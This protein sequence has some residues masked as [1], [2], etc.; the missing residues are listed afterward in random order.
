MP[1]IIFKHLLRKH[2]DNLEKSASEINNFLN[3]YDN[4][5]Q[6]IKTEFGNCISELEDLILKVSVKQSLKCRRLSTFL[7]SRRNK[8]FVVKKVQ[9]SPFIHF[10][11]KYPKRLYQTSYDDIW[12]VY[13]ELI[14]IIRQME[15]IK[16]NK[17][18]SL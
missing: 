18:K 9:K 5:R 12:V 3:D 13:D 6:P 15:N 1:N 14:E 4:N 7:K 16:Q 11:T 10:V 17:V 2:I 8:P